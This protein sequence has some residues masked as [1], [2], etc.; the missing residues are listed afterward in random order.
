[1]MDD[2]D[3]TSPTYTPNRLLNKVMECLDVENASQLAHLLECDPAIITRVSHRQRPISPGLMVQI[4]DRT[5]WHIQTV[6]ELAGM[7]FDGPTRLIEVMQ[8]PPVDVRLGFRYLQRASKR[9]SRIWCGICKDWTRQC[10][11]PHDAQQHFQRS[12]H[13]RS[14]ARP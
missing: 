13:E 2:I 5:G 6:R 9:N 7:P 1:M 10:D 8:T 12:H 11:L 4:M 3:L 14:E